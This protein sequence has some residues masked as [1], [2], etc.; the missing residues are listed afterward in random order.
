MKTNKQNHKTGA[1]QKGDERILG[2]SEF[3]EKVFSQAEESFEGRYHLKA[4]GIDVGRIAERGADI[5]DMPPEAV[6]A[7]G[8]Q[9]EI[10]NL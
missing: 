3:V 5:T 4:K 1:I 8:K 10:G 7:S 9:P 6:W 2:D